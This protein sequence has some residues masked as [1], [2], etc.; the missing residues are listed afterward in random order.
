[1]STHGATRGPSFPQNRFFIRLFIMSDDSSKLIERCRKGDLEAFDDLVALH[2]NRVYN[3]CFW[4]LGQADD[5][6]DAAQDVF[7]RAWKALD[8]FR[9]ECAFSTWL[10]RIALNVTYD[11]ARKR[12]RAPQ[13]FSALTPLD[14]DQEP[15]WEAEES[16]PNDA[17]DE[18]SLRHERRHAVRQAL[19]ALPEHHRTV[20]VL[21]DLQGHSYEEVSDLLQV[22]PGTVKSRLNRARLAL[23]RALDECRELFD[24]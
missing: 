1:M 13:A 6:S 11:A 17:P 5:A 15:E 7:I 9:G 4:Q 22:P 14:S 10:H 12:N 2:Q 16:A 20:L 18:I 19:A 23:R 8:S 3:L 24:D 21:F